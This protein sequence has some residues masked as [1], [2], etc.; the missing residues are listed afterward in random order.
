LK[1][2]AVPAEWFDRWWQPRE[3]FAAVRI[4]QDQI[5]ETEQLT[6]PEF[7]PLLEAYAAGLFTTIRAEAEPLLAL[8]LQRDR[9]P[10]FDVRIEDTILP[11]ELV[12]AGRPGHHRDEEYRQ[13]ARRAAAGLPPRLETFDPAAEATKAIPA[14]KEAVA[15][16]AAKFYTPP[17]HLLVYVNFWIFDTPPLTDREF[18]DL[19]APWYERFVEIWLLWGLNAIRCWPDPQRF[20]ADVPPPGLGPSKDT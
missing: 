20:A 12:E 2:Q 14:I 3:F 17:P 18:G 11:F 13:E 9:F 4:L 15:R 6:R 8:R 7:R 1:S 10:D 5:P 19:V 16:K